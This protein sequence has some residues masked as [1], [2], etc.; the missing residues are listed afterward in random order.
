MKFIFSLILIVLN[1]VNIPLSIFYS[2][3]QA[4]Y[5]PTWHNDKILYFAFAP[6]YW[7]LAGLTFLFGFPV[8]EISK[9]L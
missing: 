1:L 3:V 8:E 4:W 6:F 9:R 2:K 7:I 5:L